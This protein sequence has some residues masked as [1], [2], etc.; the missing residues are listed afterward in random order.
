[1]D[2]PKDMVPVPVPVPELAP[3]SVSVITVVLVDVPEVNVMLKVEV[4]FAEALEVDEI[5]VVLL[6]TTEVQD[7]ATVVCVIVKVTV[8]R[9]V[10]YSA[11][12]G[13][14][15]SPESTITYSTGRSDEC[16]RDTQATT[17]TRVMLKCAPLCCVVRDRSLCGFQSGYS[18]VNLSLPFEK[19][20]SR[21]RARDCA[22]GSRSAWW[23]YC[24]GRRNGDGRGNN[25]GYCE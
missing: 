13:S 10:Y 20:G 8:R 11:S 16:G 21:A 17:G 6:G 25:T 2:V 23:H 5:D 18:R 19:A 7:D 24:Q 4:I 12:V 22:H 1:M 14:N 9:I 3:G 15:K